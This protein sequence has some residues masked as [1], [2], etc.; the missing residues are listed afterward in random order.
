MGF[1][2]HMTKRIKQISTTRKKRKPEQSAAFAE[3]YSQPTSLIARRIGE[4]N[5][6]HRKLRNLTIAQLAAAADVA[7]AMLSRVERNRPLADI[8][9]ATSNFSLTR[10]I[11]LAHVL[12]SRTVRLIRAVKSSLP[13][14]CA[15]RL[16]LFRNSDGY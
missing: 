8:T 4:V 11:P 6:Q 13:A 12:G 16:G 3:D 5:H 2:R 15:R 9:A 14:R 7:T 1:P 10:W